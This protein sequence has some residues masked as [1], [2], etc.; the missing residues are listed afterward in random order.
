M[1]PCL[2]ILKKSIYIEH[3]CQW[4]VSLKYPI[5]QEIEKSIYKINQKGI[6]AKDYLPM[7][8]C[9]GMERNH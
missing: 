9:K 5:E 6:S 2:L 3:E 8:V 4:V 1:Y 7:L